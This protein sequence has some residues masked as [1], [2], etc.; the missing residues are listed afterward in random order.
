[1]DIKIPV[2][3]ET[4]FSELVK[5]VNQFRS[6]RPEVGTADM[7]NRVQ[8]LLSIYDAL[9]EITLKPSTGQ[10]ESIVSALYHL[11]IIKRLADKGDWWSIEGHWPLYPH[12]A[13]SLRNE[14]RS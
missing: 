13:T 3:R 11:N 2:K 7:I 4:T 6:A 10:R 1:M 12:N 14:D 9:G 8:E 5:A